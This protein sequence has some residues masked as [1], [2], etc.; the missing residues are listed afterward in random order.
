MCSVR[1]S[2]ASNEQRRECT[3]LRLLVL[4]PMVG[5]WAAVAGATFAI[6]QAHKFWM[7]YVYDIVA[8]GRVTVAPFLD[9]VFVKNT[10]ISYSMFDQDS[11]SGQYMLAAFAVAASLA[12]WVWL[13]RS[14]TTRLMAWSLALIIG[15]RAGQR[16]RPGLDRR[17]CRLLFPAR[18]RILLVCLQHGRCGDRCRRRG[19]A[20]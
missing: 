17:G 10:G 8:K 2:R 3:I 15:G 13:A 9:L 12:M 20:I 4:G 18:I 11:Q 7:L 1:L 5:A 6:D 19:A 14:D 16:P